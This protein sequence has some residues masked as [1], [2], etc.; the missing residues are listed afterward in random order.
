MRPE[1][2]QWHQGLNYHS[3]AAGSRN[4]VCQ[5]CSSAS[6][7]SQDVH[8]FREV[9]H[10]GSYKENRQFM[11]AMCWQ[12]QDAS[13]ARGI[14]EVMQRT[15]QEPPS[16]L[17]KQCSRY[18]WPHFPPPPPPSPSLVFIPLAS[19][20]PPVLVLVLVVVAA[21]ALTR[22]DKSWCQME[23]SSAMQFFGRMGLSSLSPPFSHRRRLAKTC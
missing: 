1:E 13:K 19:P 6:M 8:A 20:P 18:V 9:H 15:N 3:T 23:D 12:G 22:I 14:M 7:L 21:V 11:A 4:T 10:S 5:S 16:G 2:S 17:V